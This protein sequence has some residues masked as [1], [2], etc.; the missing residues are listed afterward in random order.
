[1]VE[2]SL[3]NRLRLEDPFKHVLLDWFMLMDISLLHFRG[4]ILLQV[5]NYI[6]RKIK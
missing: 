4:P 6:K 5:V 2:Y 3:R 1:M